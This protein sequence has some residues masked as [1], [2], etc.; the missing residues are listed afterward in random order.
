MQVHPPT[1]ELSG[2]LQGVLP[3][4]PD[5]SAIYIAYEANSMVSVIGTRT[6]TVT[7]TVRTGLDSHY[8]MASPDGSAVYIPNAFDNTISVIGRG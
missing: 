7:A 4:L 3:V 5:G 1:L 8:A 6:N 2:S